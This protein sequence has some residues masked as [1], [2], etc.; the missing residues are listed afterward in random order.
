MYRQLHLDARVERRASG[1]LRCGST[2]AVTGGQTPVLRHSS[3]FQSSFHTLVALLAILAVFAIVHGPRFLENYDTLQ[4]EDGVFMKHSE[5][6]VHSIGDCFTARPVWPGVYRPLTTN[7]YYFLGR[8]LFSNDVRVHHIIIAVLYVVNAFL[9]YLLCTELFRKPWD[10]IPP[11]LW[12]SRFAHV[13][14]VSNT[15]EFQGLL[16]VFFTLISF[17][18]F[19]VARK[20]EQGSWRYDAG[21]LTAFV[22]ALFSKET[23]VVLPALLIF[24]GWLYDRGRAWRRYLPP[25]VIAGIWAVLFVF[26]FRGTSDY[27]PTGFAYD[28]SLRA[29]LQNYVAYLLV[30]F[31]FLTYR[32]ESI[33]MAPQVAELA[34]APPAQTIFALV[35]AASFI[36]CAIQRSFGGNRAKHLRPLLF[37]FRFFII[38]TAPYVILEARLFMRYSY[39]GHAGL[40]ILSTAIAQF[41]VDRLRRRPRRVMSMGERGGSGIS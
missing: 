8:L 3:C 6:T 32:L 40:A 12:A 4:W 34:A 1:A 27:H 23:A 26:I 20:H 30:F 18:L 31:N 13:E 16:S 33:V 21:A 39:L 22:L 2:L 9:L 35:V 10:L 19:A 7:L 11:V 24:W 15:C 14:V 17:K 28:S 41:I 36:L 29:L 25:V 37:G 5:T 38:A